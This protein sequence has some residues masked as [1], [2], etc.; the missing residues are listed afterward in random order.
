MRPAA[1]VVLCAL[2]LGAGCMREGSPDSRADL[3]AGTR[4]LALFEHVVQQTARERAHTAVALAAGPE[5]LAWGVA[6]SEPT[7]ATAKKLAMSRC[8]TRVKLESV[9]ARCKIYAVNGHPQF[10]DEN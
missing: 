4:D 1:V 3:P 7:A 6:V 10:L 2:P 5:R 8:K 9:P